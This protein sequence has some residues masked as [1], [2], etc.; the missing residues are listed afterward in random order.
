MCS[1]HASVPSFSR[2]Y[3]HTRNQLKITYQLE[4]CVQSWFGSFYISLH[5]IFESSHDLYLLPDECPREAESIEILVLNDKPD[6]L[7]PANRCYGI[8]RSDVAQLGNSA[9]ACAPQVNA[10]CQPNAENIGGSP[11]NKI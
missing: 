3:R 5:P 4:L 10:R 6:L 11:I 2:K 8:I 9:C 1:F 7:N